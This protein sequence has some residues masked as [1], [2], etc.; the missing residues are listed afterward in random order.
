MKICDTA[1]PA[2]KSALRLSGDATLSLAHV[3]WVM[4]CSHAQV[5]RVV[6][7]RK[8]V[9][10]RHV[11]RFKVQ[12][13]EQLEAFSVDP[14][15]TSH[16]FPHVESSLRFILGCGIRAC[17]RFTEGVEGVRRMTRTAESGSL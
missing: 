3:G 15:A 5:D 9:M 10:K 8:Q 16:V 6:L 13:R 2:S 11:D 14:L 12:V 7:E 1:R 4:F 17:S